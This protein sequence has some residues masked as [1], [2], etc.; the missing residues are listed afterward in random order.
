[1]DRARPS[2]S[3]TRRKDTV[4]FHRENNPLLLAYLHSTLRRHRFCLKPR[5]DYSGF[6][7]MLGGPR[8]SSGQA[9]TKRNSQDQLGGMSAAV[10]EV[11]L[12][13]YST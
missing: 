10:E 3:N 2:Y 6:S 11:C 5:L 7:V 9:L 1:M 12:N 8:D 13:I 4:E